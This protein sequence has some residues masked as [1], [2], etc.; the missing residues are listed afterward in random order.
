[1]SALLAAQYGVGALVTATMHP[2]GYAKVLIQVGHEP[3]RP[4]PSVSILG[5]ESLVYPNVVHYVG[6]IKKCDGFWGLY[7]GVFPRVVSGTLG[8]LVQNAVMEKF[9]GM[10][11]AEEEKSSTDDE[12]VTWIKTFCKETAQE[13]AGRCLG[14]VASHPFHVIM[15]R[16]MVQFVGKE[17]EYNSVWSSIGEIYRN[18]GICG[19]F[20]GIAPR[21]VGEVI[22]VWITNFLAQLVNKYLVED[23]DMKS[24]T[25]AACGLIVS[26]LTYPFTLVTNIMAINGSG[27]Q[28]TGGRVYGSWFECFGHLRRQGALKRGSSM[29]WRYY[30]GPMILMDGKPYP[31]NSRFL[32]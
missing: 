3:M 12:L 6:H 9:K 7:R 21:L 18:D 1:M 11:K 24:Y 8:N 4:K 19:F 32:Q 29:F 14:I 22:T 10:N 16:C 30:Q 28:A 15:L 13:T 27:L 20:A 17:T 23:K 2:I 31:A 25:A 26:H 5:K